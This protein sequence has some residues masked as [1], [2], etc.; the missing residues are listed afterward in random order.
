MISP[1]VFIKTYKN[2]SYE[3]LL[4]IRQSLI[5]DI[6][7]FEATKSGSISDNAMIWPG[8]KVVYQFDLK[9]LAKICELIAEKYSLEKSSN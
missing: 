2:K 1:E 4:A 8:D 6:R 3:Q 7:A 5:D 9:Y